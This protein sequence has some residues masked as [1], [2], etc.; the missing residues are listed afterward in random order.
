MR[1]GF[2]PALGATT[3]GVLAIVRI[4]PIE[5]LIPGD[6]QARFIDDLTKC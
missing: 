2:S 3:F 6:R 5:V 4:L 1:P